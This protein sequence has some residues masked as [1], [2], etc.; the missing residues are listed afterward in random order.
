MAMMMESVWT[1]FVLLVMVGTTKEVEGKID[2]EVS[3][4]SV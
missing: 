2:E 3:D 4:T 1:L